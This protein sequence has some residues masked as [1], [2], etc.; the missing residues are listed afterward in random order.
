MGTKDDKPKRRRPTAA[1]SAAYK[2][3]VAEKERAKK[4][5]AAKGTPLAEKGT[6]LRDDQDKYS[7][8]KRNMGT[9]NELNR[10]QRL[11]DIQNRTNFNNTS[12]DKINKMYKK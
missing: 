7:E 12:A 5:N 8:E 6:D 2:K 4:V 11:K 9:A 10:Q 3:H 1:E